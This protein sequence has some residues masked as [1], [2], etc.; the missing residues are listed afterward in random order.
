MG[1][2]LI[3]YIALGA[4]SGIIGIL[5]TGVCVDWFEYKEG[6]TGND[7]AEDFLVDKVFGKYPGYCSAVTFPKA[8][9]KDDLYGGKFVYDVNP[10]DFTWFTCQK[11]MD[12]TCREGANGL[13]IAAVFCWISAV[14]SFVGSIIGCTACCCDDKDQSIWGGDA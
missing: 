10:S 7:K 8:I 12:A 13:S 4:W 11:V 14:V 6:A 1:V 2:C 3:G 9:T 5:L